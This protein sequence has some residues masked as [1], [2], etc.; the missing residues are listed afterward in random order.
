MPLVYVID[1]SPKVSS[2]VNTECSNTQ[3]A[4]IIN[5]SSSFLD[6]DFDVCMEDTNSIVT[7]IENADCHKAVPMSI[8]P[9]RV[10][11]TTIDTGGYSPQNPAPIGIAIIGYTN[12][13]L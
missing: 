5:F 6:T 7:E 12:Y 4:E 3:V 2:F 9:F 13:I 1:L 8:L 11:F 10:A